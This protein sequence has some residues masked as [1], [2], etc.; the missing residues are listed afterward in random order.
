MNPEQIR[1]AQ[2]HLQQLAT[3]LASG[4]VRQVQAAQKDLQALGYDVKPDGKLGPAT[5]GA[6]G[7]YRSDISTA[8]DQQVHGQEAAGRIAENNPVNRLTKLGSE[9]VP[10]GVGV[11]AG[12]AIGHYS[13]RGADE[14]LGRQVKNLASTGGLH[15]A[16]REAELNAVLRRRT[17]SDIGQFAGPALLAGGGYATRNYVAPMF[18]DPQARDVINSV[19]AGENA[20]A[21]ALGAHQAIGALNSLRKGQ[22]VDPIDVARIR[23]GNMPPAPPELSSPP[24]AS[25]PHATQTPVPNAERL[26]NAVSATG[27][28]IAA[29]AG[30]TAHYNIMKKNLNAANLPDV[31][32]ALGLARNADRASVLSHARSIMK[33]PGRSAI[34]LPLAAGGLAYEMAGSDRAEA[35]TG[36]PAREPGFGERAAAA[37]TA[38]GA[39]YGAQKLM[40]KIPAG[41]GELAGGM[42]GPLTAMSFDPLEGESREATARNIDEARQ[43]VAQHWPWG[44]QH[45]LG[46]SPQAQEIHQ[47]AQMPERSPV[48][49]GPRQSRLPAGDPDVARA[50]RQSPRSTAIQL[51]R[52]S[53]LDPEDIAHLAGTTADEVHSVLRGIPQQALAG[54]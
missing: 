16:A 19:G 42:G 28:P 7:K 10:Y 15:P 37:A 30:K 8:I 13:G 25:A 50:W 34:F 6:I 12:A 36:A 5:S 20:A 1:R 23:S 40:A 52:D 3:M 49:S 11:G 18:S 29:K 21:L 46:I 33:L 51:S 39:A 45:L 9:V 41:A 53:G 14:A 43:S 44:G 54:R 24:A 31:A 48:N 26:R 38:G 27:A 47:M 32:D 4:D 2:E 17:A 35:A 22:G